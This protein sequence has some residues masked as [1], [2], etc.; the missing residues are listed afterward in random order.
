VVK[1]QAKEIEALKETISDNN[2]E[3]RKTRFELGQLVM[4]ESKFAE[5]QRILQMESRNSIIDYKTKVE[6]AQKITND[7]NLYILKE[8]TKVSK[9]VSGV[10]KTLSDSSSSSSSS[11][12][13]KTTHLVM[14]AAVRDLNRLVNYLISSANSSGDEHNA[15][16]YGGISAGGAYYSPAVSS[17]E[18]V[19]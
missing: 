17:Q 6:Q 11:S 9:L 8:V 1:R 4:Q 18:Q 14:D 16:T 5:N 7:K 13:S 10:H 12:G 15:S 2:L 19:V 3:L